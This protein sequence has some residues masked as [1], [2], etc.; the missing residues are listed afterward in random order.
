VIRTLALLTRLRAHMK[1]HGADDGAR[2][3]A[4]DVMRYF[5][6][7][8]PEHHRDEELHVFP[9]L[10]AQA[11]PAV[12]AVVKRLQQEHVQME[13]RWAAARDVLRAIETGELVALSSADEEVLDAFASLY[14]THIA[15][16]EHTAYP[17]ASALLPA[18]APG[19]MGRDM[20]GRRG[21][22]QGH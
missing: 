14:A 12:V 20:M 4:R 19:A 5:D 1:G 18:E 15:D 2:S 10:L 11:D 13:Q 9:P 8:A 16:E 17:A 22:G 7:A 3:A 21:V 6:R